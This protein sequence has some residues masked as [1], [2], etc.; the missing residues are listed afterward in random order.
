MKKKIIIITMSLCF[1]LFFGQVGIGTSNPDSS[2]LLD[3]SST[4]RGMLIPRI[5]LTSNTDKSIVGG[6]PATGLMVYNTGSNTGFPIEGFFFWNG[7]TWKKLDDS[8]I[9]TPSITDLQCISANLTPMEL[10]SGTPY[11]GTLSVPYIGGNGGSYN[12]GTKQGPVNGLYYT[13]QEGKLAIGNGEVKFLVEGTPTITSPN[14]MDLNISFLGKNCT[15]TIGSTNKIQTIKYARTNV[16][17]IDSNTP[18]NSITSIGNLRVRYNATTPSA[19]NIEYS[20]IVASHVSFIYHKA[21]AGG[22]SL[23]N[24]GQSSSVPGTW[25]NFTKLNSNSGNATVDL[26]A[27]NRD[28]GYAIIVLHNTKEVYRVSINANGDIASNGTVPAVASGVTLFV[29]QLE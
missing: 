15:A 7:D 28:V 27:Q 19:S 2:A 21:G 5:T 18:N 16:S 6:N 20:P 17:P 29:E 26:N 11:S 9:I 12:T 13:L 23:E 24:Y 25:Y 14:T 8:E 1:N 4:N 10:T 22:V 3:I